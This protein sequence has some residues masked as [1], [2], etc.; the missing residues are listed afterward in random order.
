MRRQKIWF[1]VALLVLAL[2][3]TG[4]RIRTV[5]SPELADTVLH[6]WEQSPQ[7][8]PDRSNQEEPQEPDGKASIRKMLRELEPTAPPQGGQSR[9]REM[10]VAI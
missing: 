8:E 1:L 9:D 6:T 10:E 4:C 3:L 5:A 7:E 2:A